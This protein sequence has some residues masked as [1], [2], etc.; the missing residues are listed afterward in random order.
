MSKIYEIEENTFRQLVKES[1]S[2]TDFLKKINM[3]RGA[4]ATENFKRRCMELDISLEH[5]NKR[6][7]KIDDLSDIEF[8]QLIENSS[9]YKAVL[10]A[11]G[12]ATGRDPYNKIKERCQKLN[13]NLEHKFIK[14]NNINTKLELKDILVKNSAYKD[15]YKLKNRLIQ[16]GLLEYKCAICGNT[17]TWLNKPLSLHLDHINGDHLDNRLENLRILCPNCHT[18]TETYGSKRGT[19]SE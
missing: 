6:H 14:T 18:Q 5:F 1:T 17:G 4:N 12:L 2:I 19:K 11:L 13:I 15:S 16:E 3:G 9:S 10:D 8:I 7:S